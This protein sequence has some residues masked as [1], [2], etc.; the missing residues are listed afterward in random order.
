MLFVAPPA[1]ADQ[2]GDCSLRIEGAGVEMPG[3][4]SHVYRTKTKTYS[5]TRDRWS[6][7]SCNRITTRW[8]SNC[9]HLCLRCLDFTEACQPWICNPRYRIGENTRSLNVSTSTST[10]DAWVSPDCVRETV[11]TYSSACGTKKSTSYRVVSNSY[12]QGD[13][14]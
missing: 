8:R 7:Y 9:G 10:R 13:R 2:A 11:T 4:C 14:R 6:G 1:V 5:S 12:C 3:V